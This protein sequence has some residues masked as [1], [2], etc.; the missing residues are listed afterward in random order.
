[1]AYHG[2]G[3]HGFRTFTDFADKLLYNFGK[4]MTVNFPKASARKSI[5]YR[6]VIGIYFKILNPLYAPATASSLI[7]DRR[8]DHTVLTLAVNSRRMRYFLLIIFSEGCVRFLCVCLVAV[9]F[10][11]TFDPTVF[12]SSTTD[13]H[14]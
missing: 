7:L 14:R 5:I 1:M 13:A 11:K 2:C 9:R 8:I 12:S 6:E 10:T 4:N 3:P